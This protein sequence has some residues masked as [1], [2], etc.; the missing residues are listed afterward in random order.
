MQSYSDMTETFRAKARN[1]SV[2]QA[3]AAVA[4]IDATLTAFRDLP[5][6]DPYVRKLWCERDAM[7][8]RAHG[9]A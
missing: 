4:D 1:Y 7:V 8:E 9:R 6:T 5:M 3:R 2:K